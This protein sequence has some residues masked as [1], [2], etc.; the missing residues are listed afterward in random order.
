[1]VQL[2]KGDSVAAGRARDTYEESEFS[3]SK[4]GDAANSLIEAFDQ[5][6]VE[7][8]K[9]LTK[10]QNFTLLENQVARVAAKLADV[11]KETA[12]DMTGARTK[13]GGGG[14]GDDEDEDDDLC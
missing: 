9:E 8:V 3:F 14:G 4:E 12:G 1:M 5:G 6:D 2:S 7:K 10:T 13:G 11:C